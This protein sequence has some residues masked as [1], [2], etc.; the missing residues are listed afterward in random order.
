MVLGLLAGVTAIETR[1]LTTVSVVEPF[2]VPDVAFMVDVP[3][4]MP[5]AVPTLEIVALAVFDELQVAD[6][7][8]S[9]T[10]A[11]S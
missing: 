2:T 9:A 1:V 11:S 8:R 6:E 4:A 3:A 10:V 7:V 5:V